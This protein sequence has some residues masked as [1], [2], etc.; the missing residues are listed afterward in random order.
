MEQTLLDMRYGAES[1]VDINKLHELDD[2]NSRSVLHSEVGRAYTDQLVTMI[3]KGFV[4]GPFPEPPIENL[5]INSLFAVNQADKYRPILNLSKPEGNAYNEAII[6]HKIRKVSMSTARQVANTIYNMGPN[7]VLSKVDHVSAYKLVPV[8]PDHYF[9]QGFRWLGMIFIE[10]RLIFGSISSVP[11]YDNFHDMFSDLVRIKSNTDLQ[12]VHRTLDDQI[13]INSSIEASE[14]FINTYLEMAKRINLPLADTNGDDKAFLY[15][16]EGTILG[17]YFDTKTMTWT[18]NERKRLTHMKVLQDVLNSPSV[19]LNQ[20]QKVAGV[21]NTLVLLCPPLKYFRTPLIEQLSEAYESSPQV[22]SASSEVM[23]HFWL[24]VFHDLKFGFPI[25]KTMPHPPLK[26]ITFIT[27]AA[28]FPD[29]ERVPSFDV[30]VGAVGYYQPLQSIFYVGQA[31]WPPAFVCSSDIKQ[32]LFG[33]KTTLLEA[34]GLLLPICHRFQQVKNHHVILLVDNLPTVWAFKKGRSKTDV[35][36]SVIISALQFLAVSLECKL[37]VQHCPRLSSKPAIMADLLSRTDPKGLNL[38]QKWH[39]DLTT[40]W[41]SSL[42]AWFQ[43]PS[44]DWF[45]G[46]K[47]LQDLLST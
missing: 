42:V 9:L 45:L 13:H 1:L 20:F 41:P 17:V 47:I 21:I 39:S 46:E 44:E 32:K 19:T 25:P 11:K 24:H 34:I 10:V 8:H 27:D 15:R 37:Y 31:L 30:G 23:L 7:S 14:S 2:K 6:P 5:R 29:P 22:L 38:V 35:Y 12:T 4:A 18:Y 36:S 33:R 26:A 28:G 43:Q 40:G 3:K 16:T